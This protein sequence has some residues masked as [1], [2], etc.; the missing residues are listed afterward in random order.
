MATYKEIHGIKVQYRDS[1][2]TAVE[3][4]V[5]YNSSTGVL[6]MYASAGTWATGDACN[7]GRQAHMCTAGTQTSNLI[8]GRYDPPSG[9]T[10]SYNGSSWT[11]VADLNTARAFLGGT[12]ASNAAALAIGGYTTTAIDNNESWNGTSWTEVADIN[13]AR[14]GA[15]G[16]G[17][18]TAALAAGGII[19]TPA[20]TAV[21]EK[22]NGASWTEVGDF[23]DAR[24]YGSGGGTST[25]AIYAGGSSPG[26]V[27]VSETWDGSSYSS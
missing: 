16:Y 2:A 5:W 19:P 24:T 27:A 20:R 3:G 13:T 10:E 17:T 25:A 1:D 15:W 12:G 22:W 7:T 21:V 8:A 26:D 4:D 18:T 6:K 23:I 9:I 14:Y 11:E